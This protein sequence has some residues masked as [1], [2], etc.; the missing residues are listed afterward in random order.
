MAGLATRYR[1]D[2]GQGIGHP[3]Y[4]RAQSRGHLEHYGLRAGARQADAALRTDRHHRE[5]VRLLAERSALARRLPPRAHGLS[6]RQAQR[7]SGFHVPSL[8]V[9]QPAQATGILLYLR[10]RQ[11]T[12]LVGVVTAARLPPSRITCR[13]RPI[14]SLSVLIVGGDTRSSIFWK[15]HLPIL[16]TTIYDGLCS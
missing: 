16:G 10:G 11:T 7:S 13:P 15:Y 2:R 3:A 6:Q 5:R 1:V 12:P 14:S 8:G 4:P 9:D